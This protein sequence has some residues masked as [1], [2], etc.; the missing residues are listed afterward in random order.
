MIADG[1]ELSTK[2]YRVTYEWMVF[3]P[4]GVGVGRGV[5]VGT[6]VGPPPPIVTLSMSGAQAPALEKAIVLPLP[7]SS[8]TVVVS[9]PTTFQ[10]P[11]FEKLSVVDEPLTARVAER[12]ASPSR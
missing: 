3:P 9:V 12:P 7:A 8:F 6:G 2:P 4:P 5:D 11:L 1:G 10:P